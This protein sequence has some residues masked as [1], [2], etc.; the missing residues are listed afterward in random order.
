[1]PNIAINAIDIVPYA[2]ENTL[3]VT[4]SYVILLS[5]QPDNVTINLV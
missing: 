1:M 5:N 3:V 2:D 4:I